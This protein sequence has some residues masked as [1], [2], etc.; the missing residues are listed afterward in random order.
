M[1]LQGYFI[2]CPA[3]ARLV[4]A[5]SSVK[6]RP[7]GQETSPLSQFVSLPLIH[8]GS[9]ILNRCGFTKIVNFSQVNILI[10]ACSIEAEQERARL[11]GQI[12]P[13]APENQRKARCSGSRSPLLRLACRAHAV[14]M[15]P[16]SRGNRRLPA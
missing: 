7:A 2:A 4:N 15:E 16:R 11:S 10:V 6:P 5:T 14:Q 9:T 3:F 12:Q 1:K 13:G 8:C